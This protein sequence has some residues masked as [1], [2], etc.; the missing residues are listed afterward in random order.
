MNLYIFI[1]AVL[2]V[3]LIIENITMRYILVLAYK[4]RLIFSNITEQLL[5]MFYLG[6]AMQ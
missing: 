4:N 3:T 2:G 1:K 6:S 5:C